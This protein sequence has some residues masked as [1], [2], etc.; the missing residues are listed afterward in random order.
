MRDRRKERE[1]EGK[2]TKKGGCSIQYYERE[3][4]RDK[5]KGERE[6]ETERKKE[7]E[8]ER[9]KNPKREDVAVYSIM[10]VQFRWLVSFCYRGLGARVYVAAAMGRGGGGGGGEQHGTIV[11]PDTPP[12][13]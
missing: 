11:L 8:R 6:R 3:R 12:P 13:Y 7:R 5:K 4:K 10:Y 9:V 1:I 2:E